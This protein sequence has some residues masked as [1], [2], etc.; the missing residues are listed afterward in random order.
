[1]TGTK[2]WFCETDFG[3]I[4]RR[5]RF[6]KIIWAKISKFCPKMSVTSRMSE[7]FQ[8][9]FAKMSVTSGKGLGEIS[10]HAC[11]AQSEKGIKLEGKS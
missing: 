1:M 11:S 2:F 4:F 9:N 7:F 6:C 5:N 3:E 10:A 8:R